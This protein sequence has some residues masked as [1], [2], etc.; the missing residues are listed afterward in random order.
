MWEDWE[1]GKEGGFLVHRGELLS[2]GTQPC[3]A[4]SAFFWLRIG[5]SWHCHSDSS[6]KSALITEVGIHYLELIV[7][8]FGFVFIYLFEEPS[9]RDSGDLGN[10]CTGG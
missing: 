6:K 10:G 7:F 2:S 8:Y 9:K 1:G 3:L 5:H 4:L